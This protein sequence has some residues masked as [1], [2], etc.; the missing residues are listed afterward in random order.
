MSCL[1]WQ[2]RQLDQRRHRVHLVQPERLRSHQLYVG[3][4]ATLA[5]RVPRR[6]RVAPGEGDVLGRERIGIVVAVLWQ[7]QI[8]RHTMALGDA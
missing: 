1:R 3:R 2:A 4:P 6:E 5:I 7:E 8:V